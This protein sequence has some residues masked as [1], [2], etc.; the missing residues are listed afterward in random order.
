MEGRFLGLVVLAAACASSVTSVAA[1]EPQASLDTSVAVTPKPVDQPT[2][3][4]TGQSRIVDLSKRRGF[5]FYPSTPSLYAFRLAVGAYYDAIDPAVM[6]GF[7]IR[8][9]QATVDARYG[10]GAGWSLKGH[11][12]TMFV[13]NE[14][15]LGGGYGV[16]AGKWAFEGDFTAGVYAGK[17]AQFGFDALFLAPE[18]RPEITVGYELG[19]VALSFRASLLLMGPD[20]V[21][22][23]ELWGGLDNSNAFVGHSEMLYVENLTRSDGIWYFGLGAMT[24]RSYYALWILLPDTPG[25]FTYPRV[26]AGYEF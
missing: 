14:L 13:T 15:L 26:V 19:D 21:R 10:L 11:L 2:V 4:S 9:P 1:A 17:L 6:Y 25:L 7:N 16:H 23:G 12:N 18:Y 8:A 5:T 22:V 3:T 20:R 24:T